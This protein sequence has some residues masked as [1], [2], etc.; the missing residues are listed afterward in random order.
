ME[1]H[2]WTVNDP[3]QMLTMLHLGVDNILTSRPDLLVELLRTR[4]E[5]SDAE[6]TLLLLADLA[7]GRLW[8][9]QRTHD[10]GRP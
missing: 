7:P 9:V 4:A 2:V 8:A 1:A 6:K 10:S 5:M 3:A